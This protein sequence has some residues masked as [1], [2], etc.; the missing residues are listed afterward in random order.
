MP[1]FLLLKWYIYSTYPALALAT[2]E[3]LISFIYGLD[4]YLQMLIFL[5]SHQCTRQTVHMELPVIN[6]NG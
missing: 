3:Y 1:F 5:N 6:A 4:R 2:D